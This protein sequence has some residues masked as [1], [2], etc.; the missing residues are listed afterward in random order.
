VGSTLLQEDRRQLVA[1][2]PPLTLPPQQT[3]INR[4]LHTD[5]QAHALAGKPF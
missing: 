1:Q 4:A 3:I 2:S 5:F